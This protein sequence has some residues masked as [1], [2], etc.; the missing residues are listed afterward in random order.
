MYL[1]SRY[2]PRNAQYK[3]LAA[4]FER[5]AREDSALKLVQ[6]AE[7]AES[8]HNVQSAHYHYK[9]ACELDPPFGLPFFRLAQVIRLQDGDTREILRLLRQAVQKDGDNVSYRI[10]LADFYVDQGLN[11]NARR[12]YQYVLDR[13][14][15]N[16]KAIAGMK[17]VR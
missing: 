1:A 12:E 2:D 8:Y 15:S 3:E 6:L 11:A 5:K 16:A 10:G 17:K 13:E 7:N 4:E 14:P 9:K